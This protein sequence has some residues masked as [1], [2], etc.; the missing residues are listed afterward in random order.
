MPFLS[1]TEIEFL[2]GNKKVFKSYEYKIKSIL[3]KKI[4]SLIEK[5]IPCFHLYLPTLTL[6][7]LVRFKIQKQNR[8]LL[9]T[10]K[11]KTIKI[12]H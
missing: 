11:I 7:E 3:K 4:S 12:L 5:E 6:L 9:N 2:Q 10:V 1:K 8:I